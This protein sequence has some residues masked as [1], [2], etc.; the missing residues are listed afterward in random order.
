M[1]C[2]FCRIAGGD[3]PAEILHKDDL[4]VAFRDI[5]PQAPVHILIVPV[6]HFSNLTEVNGDDYEIIAHI[7]KVAI[8]LADRE[9]IAE[10]GYRIAVNSGKEGGQVVGHLHFHLL[11]GRQLSGDLG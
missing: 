6:K 4:V 11:G 7:F 10:S 5:A 3:I 1:D 2:I 9:G 8:E